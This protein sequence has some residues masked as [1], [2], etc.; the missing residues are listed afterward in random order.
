M[1]GQT[2]TPRA[3]YRSNQQRMIAGVCGGFAEY[4]AIDV[5]LVRIFWLV[6]LFFS[7]FGLAAYLVCIFVIKN[8]PG[9]QETEPAKKRAE[10]AK[11]TPLKNNSIIGLILII[12]LIILISGH[13]FHHPFHGF[14]HFMGWQWHPHGFDDFLSFIVVLI[15]FGYI[16][17]K[18]LTKDATGSGTSRL[19]RSK[20]KRMFGGIC[21]GLADLWQIDVTWIRLGFIAL[22]LATSF[23]ASICLYLLLLIAIPVEK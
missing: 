1:K 20:S 22:A 15:G 18:Y 4:F 9:A 17:I 5:T 16:A 7:G 19:Y 12:F 8:N 23:I 2:T 10:P 6:S 21:G 14:R 13:V 3:L 11:E